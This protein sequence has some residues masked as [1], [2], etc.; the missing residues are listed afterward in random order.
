MDVAFDKIF[1][2]VD[3]HNVISFDIFDT[4]LVR[5]YIKPE[6]VFM[7]IEQMFG[8]QNFY[9]RRVE[10]E[11][12]VRTLLG[13]QYPT[14]DDIYDVLAK[15]FVSAKS[16]EFNLEKE[17][18]FSRHS[19]K[20]I[21]DYAV[22]QNKIIIIV[23][24]MYYD[25]SRISELLR[26]NG[27]LKY[28]KLFIS[29][30]CNASKWDGSLWDKIC[31]DYRPEDIFHIGDT[32]QSD[33]VQAQKRGIHT[34]LIK[35]PVDILTEKYPYLQTFID[36]HSNDIQTSGIVG[37]LLR[38]QFTNDKPLTDY[39]QYIGFFWGG[40]LCLGM[41]KFVVKACN[42][43]NIKECLFVA[44]DGYTIKKIVN[45]LSPQIKSHY[46]YAPRSINQL[47]CLDYQ[48]D[49]PWTDKLP[50]LITLL[51]HVS[52]EFKKKI[53]GVVDRDTLIRT[54]TDSKDIINPI[55]NEISIE[56]EEYIQKLNIGDPNIA[57]FD[58]SAGHFNSLKLL[59]RF[60]PEKNIYGIYWLTA[61]NEAQK[62]NYT[63]SEY[64]DIK[65][66]QFVNYN[67]LE[68][69]ITAPELPIRYIKNKQIIRIDNQYERVRMNLQIIMSA[70]ETNFATVYANTFKSWNI[71]FDANL[72]VDYLNCA[73]AHL[74]CNDLRTSLPLN[75]VQIPHTQNTLT[76][77][78]LTIH[79]Y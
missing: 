35:K 1:K 7:H 39:W 79:T 49:L 20:K 27:Y 34:L 15:E 73:I 50:S 37:P 28:S 11:D 70:Q 18:L 65:T 75:M 16:I 36:R 59:K 41:A 31:M 8:F 30:R 71:D 25:K 48:G 69:L 66:C 56:Y 78:I 44:R 4:L 13:K 17:T 45:M 58:L 3:R 26:R 32:R 12:K 55:I 64:Q 74:K 19:I 14:Y 21:Y 57:L 10:A 62:N 54:I 42:D 76:Y 9:K 52:S 68:F 53:T 60:L 43:N 5:P 29:G 67:L 72:L 47:L 51:S 77:F 38:R 23:T 22:A 63:I 46:V 24:D 40:P 6:H 2:Q 61:G 33:E